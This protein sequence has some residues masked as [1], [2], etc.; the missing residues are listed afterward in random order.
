M[1]ELEI[2]KLKELIEFVNKTDY[3]IPTDIDFLLKL[4]YKD[5]SKRTSDEIGEFSFLISQYA[6]LLQK[7]INYLTSV[8]NWAD[9]NLTQKINVHSPSYS[10]TYE[11][12]KAAA[13]HEIELAQFL[14]ILKNDS[15]KILDRLSY[16]PDKCKNLSQSLQNIQISR[17]FS[18]N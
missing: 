15:K 9:V 1:V 7:K 3:M 2:N 11:E 10:G 12:R 17:K 8:Y 18:A 14:F 16:L 4:H 5:I 6:F 13:I